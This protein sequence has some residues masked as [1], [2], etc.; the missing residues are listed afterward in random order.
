[1]TDILRI[2]L[3]AL[4]AQQRALSVAS[5]NIANA[6][7]PGYSR[8]RVELSEASAQRLGNDFV[9]T[10]V[11]ASF[12]R[13]ITDEVIAQQLRAASSGFNRTETFVGYAEALDNLLA[14]DQTGLNVTL[15]GFVNA[16]QDV[17][18]DPSSIAARQ[19]LLSE[20]RNLAS[21]FDT[22][23]RRLNEIGAEASARLTSATTEINALGAGIAD[24]NLQIVTAGVS[25]DRP[26]PSDLLDQR[27][28]LLERLSELVKV[29]T[30]TQNDGTLSVF[31]GS[32][33]TLVLGTRAS[34]LS[35]VPGTFDPAQPQV[36]LNGPNGNV[37]I[38]Q[39][40]TGGELGGTLDFT[41]E[42]LNPARAELGRIAVGLVSTFNAAHRNG[43]DLNGALGGDFFAIAG[44]QTFGAATNAGT[45]AVAA[46]ITS[47]G[48]LEPTNY[49]LTFAGGTYSLLR[50]DTGSIVPMTGTGTVA[51]PFRADG[52]AMVV[53]GTPAAGDQF[54]VQPTS[55]VP[56]TLRV[57]VTDAERI[58]AAA[59]T[60]TRAAL[61]NTG[62]GTISAGQVVDVTNP[63]LLTA[64]TIQFL[65]ATTYS[66]DGAGSFAYTPGSDITI[67]G[68]RVQITGAPAVG[69]RF[70]IESNAG[71]VGDNRN[72]LAL[73][74]ALGVGILDG[75][76]VTLHAAVGQF[77]TAVGA[78]TLEGQNR[79]D[80]QNLL[81]DQ[82]RQ[83]LDSVRGVNLDEEAADVLRFQQL[84]QAAAQTMSVADTLFNSLLAALR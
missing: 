6:S 10:G 21:R 14:D 23:D 30:A 34:S 62:S 73:S 1:M 75:G 28:R 36:V 58:A 70:V 27:D 66:V 40:L 68:T 7:T 13:R 8:Q 76:N 53:S 48:A 49:R 39:F 11:N 29:E 26:P 37:N 69:D 35:V 57:L 38:T 54:L 12:T 67:K 24:I 15:Q 50:V 17:A 81:V 47:V 46:T 63:A 74:N 20:A 25:A 22:F 3:S 18:D 4:L 79:R 72:A 65:T 2:G 61:T 55:H 52:L 32:G 44:P 80:A 84:Y 45:G 71:G 43:M 59:P 83:R 64:S 77:V 41:R 78:Q 42:M 33:Q 16:V 5:N 82:N 60:R 56:G 31:I 9:G 51:D 19:V